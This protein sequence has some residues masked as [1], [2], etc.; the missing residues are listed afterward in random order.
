MKLYHAIMLATVCAASPAA[1]QSVFDGTWKLDLGSAKLPAKPNVVI[2]KDGAFRCTS[3]TPA[4]AVK[5][6]GAFHTV[7]GNPDFDAVAISVIDQRTA[8][9]QYRKSGKLI[10]TETDTVSADGQTLNYVDI[11]SSATSGKTTQEVGV[12]TRVGPMLAGAHPVSGSWRITKLTSSTADIAIFHSD[13]THLDTR[14]PSGIHY[15]PAFAGGFV[16]VE[17]TAPGMMVA[18]ATA[19]ARA[20]TIRYKQ[21]GKV[22]STMTFTVAPDGRSAHILSRNL[23][24]GTSVSGTALKQ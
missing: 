6:D 7:T 20:F 11:D 4:Y 5:A 21:D 13:G 2:L 1:A 3:C 19:G 17:G 24:S 23:M 9:M 10:D 18:V 15:K 22:R 12:Q 8:R 14:L 16:P